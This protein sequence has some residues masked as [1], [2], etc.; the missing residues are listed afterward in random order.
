M[1]YKDC[2]LLRELI[3]NFLV[4]AIVER[5]KMRRIGLYR[6]KTLICGNIAIASQ[7]AVDD[8][9]VALMQPTR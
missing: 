4:I 1:N 6:L 2:A 7:I 3:L 9:P 5:I 8:V